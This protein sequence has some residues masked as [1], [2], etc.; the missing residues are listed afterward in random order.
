MIVGES[1]QPGV[2]DIGQSPEARAN[3]VSLVVAACSR[4]KCWGNPPDAEDRVAHSRPTCLIAENFNTINEP[5]N[6]IILCQPRLHCMRKVKLCGHIV[7]QDVRKC[8]GRFRI[9]KSW[10]VNGDKSSVL[11]ES[12]SWESFPVTFNWKPAFP[13]MKVIQLDIVE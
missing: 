6:L 11:G 13:V 1:L 2:F 9:R 4:R 10:K 12:P 3:F 7:L 8:G 5:A